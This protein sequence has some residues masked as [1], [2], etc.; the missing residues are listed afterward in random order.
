MRISKP[1]TILIVACI[2]VTVI[3]AV[4]LTSTNSN[5]P[6]DKGHIQDSTNDMISM[7]GM[8]EYFPGAADITEVFFSQNGDKASL[9]INVA[10]SFSYVR[11]NESISWFFV[12]TFL[13]END[14][15]NGYELRAEL[16]SSGLNASVTPVGSQHQPSCAVSLEDKTVTFTMTLPGLSG[17]SHVQ[18][19]V[20]SMYS[21]SPNDLFETNPRDF[22]PD[23]GMQTT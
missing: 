14:V 2:A 9:A 22:A 21:D 18:W 4:V 5:N 12:L 20:V 8:G 11:I 7:L 19:R 15:V 3:V 1:I 13:N 23:E 16:N 10:D 17:A 6:S